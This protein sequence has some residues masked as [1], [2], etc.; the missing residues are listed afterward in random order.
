MTRKEIDQVVG[1][2]ILYVVVLPHSGSGEF[3]LFQGF[4]VNTFPVIDTIQHICKLPTSIGELFRTRDE[5]L[6]FRSI[7]LAGYAIA[8]L[9]LDFLQDFDGGLPLTCFVSHR[10]TRGS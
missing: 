9:E 3:S 1:E 7:G 2:H 8:L 10:D 5:A 6:R 4:S